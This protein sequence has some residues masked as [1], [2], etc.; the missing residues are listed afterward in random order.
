MHKAYPKIRFEEIIKYIQPSRFIVKS[1]DYS[2]QFSTPV[3]TAGKSFIIGYTDEKDGIFTDLPAIIFDDFTTATKL[4]TF[5]FKV[6]SS[7]IKIL[8][9]NKDLINIKYAYYY[10]QTI[11][12]NIDTHK[13]FWIST[14]SKNE[15]QLPPLNIQ[16]QI[17]TKI[18][19]LFSELDKGKEQL[20][21]A[22][23]QLKTYRQSVLKWAF[24]GR[25]TNENVK[26]GELPEGWKWVKL[27]TVG[28]IVTGSTPSKKNKSFY[29]NDFPFYK[30]TDL[31][32]GYNVKSAIDNLSLR[33]LN[34]SRPLP[35]SSILV[36]CIG[37]T[38]GKTGIIRKAGAS[39]QQIN[40]I[41]TSKDFNPNFIYFQIIGPVF[42]KS[43][44]DNASSTTL[45]ILNKSKFMNLDIVNCKIEE[46]TTIA[47][48]I[49][50]R[51]S[52]S[53][54]MEEM[55]ESSLLQIESLRQSILK[56]A[57]EGKL[58]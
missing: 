56:Q 48:E 7:A 28:E 51:L 58:V 8:V 27:K 13:R 2:N 21:K 35:V 26:D 6:K 24:E 34:Q 16:Q 3:L 20:E 30:P 47:H 54:K 50:S 25:L 17:I 33:G 39:N 45:P 19:E 36:T 40:A 57:F 18:E 4:V 22:K 46:Q 37:A 1:T 43:I 5:P 52:I 38:I 42:Q 53:D 41:I 44:K 32:A 12:T 10:M 31:E 55:I 49:E 11:Q 29:S 23:E 15:I 9:P 14:Y